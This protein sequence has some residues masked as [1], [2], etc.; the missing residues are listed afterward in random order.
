MLTSVMLRSGHI[1]SDWKQGVKSDRKET[2]SFSISRIC[3]VDPSGESVQVLS[4]PG[5]I[6]TV[7]LSL[8]C[9]LAQQL[10]TP[11][12]NEPL[13]YVKE[14]WPL[15]S[16]FNHCE[17]QYVDPGLNTVARDRPVQ[18][19]AHRHIDPLTFIQTVTSAHC[20]ASLQSAAHLLS[21]LPFVLSEPD[22]SST[23]FYFCSRTPKTEAG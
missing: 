21:D 10:P 3:R 8:I 17:D 9:F 19:H 2:Q 5:H 6:W 14:T 1:R 15:R 13:L 11:G 22:W 23:A 7:N 20:S 12:L 16:P 18:P 4:S